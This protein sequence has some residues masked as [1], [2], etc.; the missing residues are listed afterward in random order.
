MR[1]NALQRPPKGVLPLRNAVRSPPGAGLRRSRRLIER[2]PALAE[3]EVREIVE[4]AFFLMG[5]TDSEATQHAIA[6]LNLRRAQ[7]S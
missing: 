1:R 2:H 7:W 4:R 5:R 3:D 6:V